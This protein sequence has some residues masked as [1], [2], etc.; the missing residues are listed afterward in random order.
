MKIFKNEL[1]TVQ[2]I[3]E[4]P[5]WLNKHIMINNHCIYWK[6]W[7]KAGITYINDIMNKTNGHFMSHG[8]LQENYNIK[9]NHIVT[10]Q[11]HS[12]IPNNWSKT[13][14]ENIYSTPLANIQ[15]SIC[16]NKSKLN[17][18]K[19][20]RKEDYS[21][22]INKFSHLPKA[23]Y[24][25]FKN[26]DDSFWKTIFKIPFICSRQTTIKTLQDNSQNISLK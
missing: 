12:I 20:K 22:L 24:I 13:L 18:E 23:I 21:H 14:K 19:V 9:T 16:I 1:H 7:N 25:N 8:E 3:L 26:K 2:Y 4:Q 5:L 11:I 10:L 15:N 6:A 17:V